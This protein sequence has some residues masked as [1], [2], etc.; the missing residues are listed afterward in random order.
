MREL[1][2]GTVQTTHAGS[3]PT[4]QAETVQNKE[5][6]WVGIL[7]RHNL[8][9]PVQVNISAVTNQIACFIVLTNSRA[10]HTG[11]LTPFDHYRLPLR[12]QAGLSWAKLIR[13]CQ[14]EGLF[15]S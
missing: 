7:D 3:L 14:M 5:C 12:G 15:I 1:N 13:L 11:K 9:L 6:V 8:K 2:A 4:N 10:Y